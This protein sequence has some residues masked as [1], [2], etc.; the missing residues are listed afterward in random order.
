MRLYVCLAVFG[1]VLGLGACGKRG[2]LEQ[3]PPLWG[4]PSTAPADAAGR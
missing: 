3:P 1:L 4:Q 2:T